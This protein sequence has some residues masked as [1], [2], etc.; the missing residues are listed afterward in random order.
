MA[1]CV[2]MGQTRNVE[3]KIELV[4]LLVANAAQPQKLQMVMN[5]PW[6]AEVDE[7]AIELNQIE[8]K[9]PRWSC[10]A[11]AQWRANT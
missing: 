5:L 11:R 10:H 8:Y 2:E 9:N 7:R 3:Q 6:S 1:I 4:G